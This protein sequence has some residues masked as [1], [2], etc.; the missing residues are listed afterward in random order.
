MIPAEMTDEQLIQE[1]HS[2]AL[3]DEGGDCDGVL[4]RT[5]LDRYHSLAGAMYRRF[6][7]L[8][9]LED[10]SRTI[11][12]HVVGFELKRNEEHSTALVQIS[13]PTYL[14]YGIKAM[15]ECKLVF[16]QPRQETL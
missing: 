7:R 14:T 3:C 12:G 1:L 5:Y 16:T 2:H 11:R 10:I 13:L 4:T 9:E 6:R 15:S 8:I